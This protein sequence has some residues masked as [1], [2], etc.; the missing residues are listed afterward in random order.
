[1]DSKTLPRSGQGTLTSRGR[2]RHR[3][4]RRWRPAAVAAGACR[5]WWRSA[6]APALARGLPIVTARAGVGGWMLLARACRSSVLSLREREFVVAARAL[7][8]TDGRILVRHIL[9]N[10]WSIILVIVT[11][12]L[13]RIIL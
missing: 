5:R 13:R 11:I 12:D 8:A 10:L 4:R 9:P 1:M 6:V 7:G 2:A 3:A